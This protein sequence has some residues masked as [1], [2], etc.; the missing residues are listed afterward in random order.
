VEVIKIKVKRIFS[1]LLIFILAASSMV[2]ADDN[3]LTV[4]D[5]VKIATDASLQVMQYTNAIV[6]YQRDYADSLATSRQI[7]D[8][9]DMDARFRK[10]SM[11]DSRTPEEEAEYQILSTMLKKYMSASERLNMTITSELTPSNMEYMLNV[12]KALL[13]STKENIYLSVYKAFNNITKADDAI[14]VKTSLI[15]NLENNYK[16]AILKYNQGKLSSNGLKT[17]ELELQKA[18]I[19]LN[20]LQ[21]QKKQTIIGFNKL[22]GKPLEYQYSEYINDIVPENIPMKTLQEYIN[23]AYENNDD[24]KDAKQSFEIAKKKYEL[25]TGLYPYDTSTNNMS[26]YIDYNNA[27]N[28]YDTADINLQLQV[29]SVFTSFQNQLTNLERNKVNLGLQ[30]TKL[31]EIKSKYNLGLATELDVND[32]YT[33]YYES[34]LNYLSSTR[35]TWLAKLNLDLVCG[36]AKNNN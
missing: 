18:R 9:L 31:S 34:Q 8:M 1:A 5:A 33:S 14:R 36:T 20:T 25:T 17:M 26:A 21:V 16:I 23:L 32:A 7:N 28:Q 13:K 3:S 27:K 2:Y 12:N 11:K 24:F 22:L 6:R 35:D 4:A 29:R 15:T 10:L 30:D 19:E